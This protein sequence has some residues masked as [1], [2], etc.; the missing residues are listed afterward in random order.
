[1][2]S[3]YHQCGTQEDQ[4]CGAE[5]EALAEKHLGLQVQRAFSS[6][7]VDRAEK[8]LFNSSRVY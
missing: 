5:I 2:M 7:E 8:R 1:M 4:P 3:F 6:D